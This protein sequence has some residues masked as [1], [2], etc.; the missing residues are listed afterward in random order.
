MSKFTQ[1]RSESTS[2]IWHEGEKFSV[3][4]TLIDGRYVP[5]FFEHN[6][7]GDGY[8]GSLLFDDANNPKSLTD[9]D[10]IT[11]YLPNEVVE[12]VVCNGFTVDDQ[13]RNESIR[14]VE[15]EVQEVMS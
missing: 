4:S 5:Y 10:G 15:F 13:F 3:W 2:A 6:D 1:H 12:M 7:Y 9:Y 8:A 14:G 11:G